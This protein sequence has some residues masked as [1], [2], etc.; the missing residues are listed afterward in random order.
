MTTRSRPPSNGPL[1]VPETL[2]VVTADHGHGYEVYG[3]VDIETFNAAEND[4][5]RRNAIQIYGDAGFPTYADADGDF[6]PDDWNV[7]VTLAGVV[8][9]FPSYTEDFQVSP[10]PRVPAIADAD[11]NYIDNPDDDPTASS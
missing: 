1:R 9:N 6:F 10:T 2:I 7:S 4:A 11:G 5:G 3:T 8:N